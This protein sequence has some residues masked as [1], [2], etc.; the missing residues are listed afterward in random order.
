[1]IALQI[2]ELKAFMSKLLATNIFDDFLLQEATLQMGI[3]YVI[4]GHINKAFY[5]NEEDQLAE[6]STFITYGEVRGTLFDLI[7]GKRTPL[8]FQVLLQLPPKKCVVLFP[9]GLDAHLIKGLVMNIR[10]D[11]SKALITSGISYTSFSLDKAPELIWD[12]AMMNFLRRA[13]ISFEEV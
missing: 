9:D 11:G 8:G 12:E 5:Q 7:K 3:G 6:R 10:F 1:M 2:T 13:G 4:D